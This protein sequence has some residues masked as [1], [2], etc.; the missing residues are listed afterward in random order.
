MTRPAR[1][2]G[3]LRN[4]SA[5]ASKLRFNDFFNEIGASRK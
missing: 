1:Y 2:G 5:P 4:A 3:F